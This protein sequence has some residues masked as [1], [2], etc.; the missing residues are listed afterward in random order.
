MPGC[1]RCPITVG[2]C[3][4]SRGASRTSGCRLESDMGREA[5][6]ASTPCGS[7]DSHP[8][9]SIMAM[10][11]LMVPADAMSSTDGHDSIP[12]RIQSGLR[13]IGEVAG[14]GR[15]QDNFERSLVLS[16]GAGVS[17]FSM[18][19]A[20]FSVDQPL[21]CGNT[22]S[23]LTLLNRSVSHWESSIRSGAIQVGEHCSNILLQRSPRAREARTTTSAC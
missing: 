14:T 3:A 12:T 23:E 21:T 22:V 20:F 18:A 1:I 6:W 8:A 2:R 9:S 5:A 7:P 11:S 10:R 4:P 16:A 17:D 15:P 13:A 19:R